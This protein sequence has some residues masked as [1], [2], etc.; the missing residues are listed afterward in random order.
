[1]TRYGNVPIRIG[2]LAD[3]Q[4]VVVRR[5]GGRHPLPPGQ[6]NYR[7]YALALRD[8]G[9]T[10]VLSTLAVGSLR[11]DIQTGALVSLDQFLDFTKHRAPT[12]FDE[13]G[14]A[15]TDMSWP[16]CS[17][18]RRAIASSAPPDEV[19]LHTTGCYVGVDGPRYETAA[20]VAMFARNG[21][22]VIGSSG[23]TEAVM[24]REAGLCHGAVGLVTNRAAGIG[25]NPVSNQ[26]VLDARAKFA[27]VLEDVV[28]GSLHHM[29][30]LSDT[31][32][33]C[34]S[35]SGIQ[36]PAWSAPSEPLTTPTDTIS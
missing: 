33:D 6:V 15:F 1:V 12:L 7:A 11:D 21:G 29:S 4:I 25:N 3:V 5:H 28:V 2:Q 13:S 27:K 32:C 36:T 9:V 20:E 8:I 26:D 22:T 34:P 19:S 31:P 35:R 10:R 18:V 30:K 14:F 24:L 16:Y 17:V 23:V